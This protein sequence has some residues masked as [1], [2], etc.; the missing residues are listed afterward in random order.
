MLY[1]DTSLGGRVS[2]YDDSKELARWKV[3][4]VE[5]G[6]KAETLTF[7]IGA[8]SKESTS[9]S[10]IFPCRLYAELITLVLREYSFPAIG[11]TRNLFFLRRSIVFS[12]SGNT[13]SKKSG[14]F[15]LVSESY[16]SRAKSRPVFSF[17]LA[18]GR[19]L[20]GEQK[21]FLFGTT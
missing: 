7:G 11:S 9:A 16:V 15:D 20:E 1:T 13:R 6:I 19:G 12:T 3:K 10:I 21:T 8:I 2:D 14:T 4:P 18:L 17:Q 5:L